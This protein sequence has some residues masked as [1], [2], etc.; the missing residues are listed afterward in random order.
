MEWALIINNLT[1]S[2]GNKQSDPRIHLDYITMIE[3]SNYKNNSSLSSAEMLI[4]ISTLP[5]SCFKRTYISTHS[6]IARI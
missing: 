5:T 6:D 2:Y 4:Y 1:A 3:P